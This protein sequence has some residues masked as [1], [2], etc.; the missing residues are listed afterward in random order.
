[1]Q[2]ET[3]DDEVV[4]P[5]E[6][7]SAHVDRHIKSKPLS[8]RAKQ[9]VGEGARQLGAEVGQADER[10]EQRLHEKFDHSVGTLGSR[11]ADEQDEMIPA[12]GLELLKLLT[13]PRSMRQAILLA[14]ILKRPDY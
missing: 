4:R 10:L 3:G 14:E 6:S 5:G 11:V 13:S 12:S 1:M 7:V 8:E 2:A 9:R